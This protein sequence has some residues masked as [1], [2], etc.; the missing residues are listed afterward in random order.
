MSADFTPSLKPY[1]HMDNFRMWCQ[2]V[3]PLVYDDSLGYYEVLCKLVAYLNDIINNNEGMYEDIEDLQNA[4][5]Q[6]QEYVNNYFN[7]LDLQEEVNNW[8]DEALKDGRLEDIFSDKVTIV[9]DDYVNVVDSGIKNDGSDVSSELQTLINSHGNLFFPEGTYSFKNIVI[10][11]NAKLKG[12]NA[13]INLIPITENNNRIY[14][15]FTGNNFNNVLI[16]GFAFIGPGNTNIGSNLD[17]TS[18]LEFYTGKTVTVKNCEFYN[19]TN[20]PQNVPNLVVNRKGVVLTCSDVDITNIYSNNFHDI[21]GEEMLEVY[22]NV[23]SRESVN[24]KLVNNT[25]TSIATSA[26][27]FIGN[28]ARLEGNRINF[29]YDGSAYNILGLIVDIKNEYVEGS[30]GSVYDT[31]EDGLFQNN[32]VSIKNINFNSN[33]AATS[34]CLSS[35]SSLIIE[36][37]I[38]RNCARALTLLFTIVESS[39]HKDVATT[40]LENCNV[41]IIN[42]N[43]VTT[44]LLRSQKAVN[45]NNVVLDGVTYEGYGTN[46]TPIYMANGNIKVINSRFTNTITSQSSSAHTFES[47]SDHVINSLIAIGNS[48][49]SNGANAEVLLLGT[50]DTIIVVG[51]VKDG[52]TSNIASSG[53]VTGGF[54]IGYNA[55][56]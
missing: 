43:F 42:S 40:Q 56:S 6:L 21:Y 8:L 17:P 27:T 37:V 5:E 23:K 4:F 24:V 55:P 10:P 54:N 9:Y 47:L 31:S 15:A 45:D 36:N 49:I 44:N 2:K 12:F 35:A 46:A 19:I 14:P 48:V 38:V 53:S 32:I 3:L 29:T 30:Y 52:A 26:L 18:A 11:E 20:L 33:N 41:K 7:D 51:N 25:I 13:K 50:A 39:I 16:D 1:K 22:D 34:F 28:I